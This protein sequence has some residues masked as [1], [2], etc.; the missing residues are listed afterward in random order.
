MEDYN[1]IDLYFKRDE[2]AISETSEKYGKLC[3]NIASRIVGDHQAAEE[4]VNDSYMALWQRIPPERPN[5][6][7]AFIVKI[8]RNISIRRLKY[9]LADKR[10]PEVLI[11]LDELEEIIPDGESFKHIEDKELGSWISEFLYKEKEVTRNIFIRKYWYLDS[12]GD[13]SRKFGYSESKIK[14]I[15]FRVRNKLK[16]YLEERGVEVI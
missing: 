7:C 4:C 13:L 11:S 10:N 9:R 6:F 12:V 8:V 2:R 5:S 16:G 3:H 1:I 15:L 14:S